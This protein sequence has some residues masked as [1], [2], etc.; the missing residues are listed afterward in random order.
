MQDQIGTNAG[1]VFISLSERGP[2]TKTELSKNLNLSALDLNRAIGRLV[3]EGKVG[4]IRDAKGNVK[5]G[6]KQ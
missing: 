1:K 4:E 6:P 3:R 5:I 2:Q